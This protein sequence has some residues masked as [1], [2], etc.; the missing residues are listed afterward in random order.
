M[1]GV[2]FISQYGPLNENTGI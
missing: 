2:Y 1:H